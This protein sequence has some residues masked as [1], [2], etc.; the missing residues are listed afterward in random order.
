MATT[1]YDVFLSF[2]SDD[3]QAVEQIALYLRDRV[4]LRPWF[5]QWELIPGEP[6]VR[7]LER[8]LAASETCAVFVGQSGE[9]PWQQ[10]EVETVLRYQV[11]NREFRVIPVL[12]PD[13]PQ[14][15]ELPMFL[16]GNTWVDFR[17]KDLDD[18][19]ALWRLQCGI[20]GQ[21]P[22]DGLT[23]QPA[24]KSEGTLSTEILNYYRKAEAL[25]EKIPLAGF[26]TAL[27]VP[28]RIED[29]YVPLRAM[30]DDRLTGTSCF[31]DAEDAEKSLQECRGG[32]EIS[33]P[34]AFIAAEKRNRRGIVILGDPGSGKTTYMKRVLLWCLRGGLDALGLPHEM[35]PVFLPLR[36]LKD[37]T[38][39]LDD[40][41]QEQLSQPNLGTPAGFGK[42][43]L[44][45][46]NLLFLLD[47]LDE[48]S[49]TAHRMKVSR[50]IETALKIYHSCR[51]VVTCRFAGYTDAARLDADFLEMHIRPMTTEQ[52]EAFVRN[53]YR[54]VET[55][56]SR[57]CEQAE[58]IAQ[59]KADK[60]IQRLRQPDFRARRVFELTRNPLLLTNI[61]L[62]HLSRGNLPHTRAALYDE[63][64][65]VLLERW[66]GAAGIRTQIT[67]QTG[68]RV[69]QP[70]AF[71]LH[72]KEGRTRATAAELAPV[73]APVLK[74]VGWQHGSA[75]AFLQTV[76]DESGVLTGWD[77]EHYGFMHLGFQEYLAAREIQNKAF[78]DHKLL[79]ELALRF[80][81]SWWQEVILLMLALENPSIFV[82]FMREVVKLPVFEK[83]QNFIAMCL[84]DAA[85]KSLQPFL[86]LL[87]MEAGQDQTL[88]KRQFIALQI[89]GRMDKE[90][91]GTLMPTLRKH[92]SQKIRQWLREQLMH[93]QQNVMYAEQGGYELVFIPG[94]VFMM[95]SPETE[96][97]HDDDESPLHEVQVAD[98][99]I[100][101]YPVTNEEYGRF[102]AT[103][104]EMKEP[105]FWGD[106]NYNQPN[107]PVVGVSWHEAQKY[108]AWAGLSLPTE[109]Q[110]EYAC[111][112]GTTT[113]YY[114]G[115]T[116]DDL[117]RAGW[118]T[119]NSGGKLHP[120]GAKEP[121]VFG[122]YDMH[123][124]VWEWC[125]DWFYEDYYEN[126][127]K[128]N[129]LGP[130][131]GSHRVLRGG[132]RGDIPEYCR[133]AVRNFVAPV[134][135][136]GF[137]G[138]RLLR[139]P[140]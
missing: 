82:E 60:L 40:F 29:I 137:V 3:R 49:E 53:W 124:N 39:N 108:A 48:V 99:Y 37:V 79:P 135:R 19:D 59:D 45:R 111:R 61:C 121:N 91:L 120:V 54:I 140:G 42:R 101:R 20:L 138:F 7:S 4:H 8:G 66:R 22:G 83:N 14:Q 55:S 80:G 90:V 23:P 113:R 96:A 43:L 116:E 1:L 119:K 110:W 134:E 129:P 47:G 46:G 85:E 76:R 88:W 118:Y 100:G 115:D 81:E 93:A 12:L 133:A 136:L 106:R 15:P 67:S 51:F 98:F 34:D 32:S 104:P 44:Q 17:G 9:G 2:N 71:W 92:P 130:A 31:A 139:T 107:Q 68:R 132:S 30:I 58:I 11:K 50:W 97:G 103:N 52:A 33:I 24:K 27:R 72:Q 36:D 125:Q 57:D 5:D 105:N 128:E 69:L 28:I 63:C 95:G 21:A 102:L 56:H 38:K 35:V 77:Q 25:H 18:G 6:W 131:S 62:V 86:E 84:D 65:D 123:G 10:R 126:S 75:Q 16:S 127:P 117:D 94:G 74:T 64:L 89:V 87:E 73:I 114:T 26:K 78:R 109:A 13:A 70:V 41:I 122:L 112:A